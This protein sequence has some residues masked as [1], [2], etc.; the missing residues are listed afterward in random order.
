PRRREQELCADV[1]EPPARP[2]SLQRR[3]A[4][5]QGEAVWIA[6]TPGRRRVRRGNG[7]VGSRRQSLQRAGLSNARREVSRQ[8]P[9]LRRHHRIALSQGLWP[10]TESTPRSGIHLAQD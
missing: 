7:A 8:D 5:S 10:A 9:L 4:L 6:F 2:E 3:Q 1:E